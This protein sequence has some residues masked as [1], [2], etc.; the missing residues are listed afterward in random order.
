M[1]EIDLPHR[2]LQK[3]SISPGGEH[4]WR[5]TDVEEVVLAAQSSGLGCLGGQVQFQPTGG[6]CEAYW[7][8]VDSTERRDDE[9]WTEYVARS[10]SEV[11]VGFRRLAHETDFVSEARRWEV[12]R[13]RIDLEHYDPVADLWFVL[14]FASESAS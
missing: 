9:A 2:L 10:V 4:A 1:V 3:A 6:V 8:S 5:L 11:L 13:T 12:L 14:Y 7:L